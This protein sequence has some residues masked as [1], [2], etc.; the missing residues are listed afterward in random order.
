[1]NNDAYD[2]SYPRSIDFSHVRENTASPPH[3]FV[4]YGTVGHY[5]GTPAY[6]RI[7]DGDVLVEVTLN[8][9][10][11][12]VS[13]RVDFDTVD[14]GGFYLPLSY[15]QRVVVGF[16]NGDS[17]EAVIIGRCSDK[18][19]PFPDEV[20]DVATSS[21][22][23]NAPCFAFLKTQDGQLLCIETG[24]NADI[25]IHSGASVQLKATPSSQNL[26]TGRTHIGSDVEFSS[27]PTAATVAEDG[28]VEEGEA[29]G[30]FSPAPNSKGTTNLKLQVYPADGVVR[31]DDGIV[32][33]GITDPA[34][35]AW[36]SAVSAA[37]IP[38]IPT[39]PLQLKS[40]HESCSFNT[41]GD[42]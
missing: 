40:A 21:N 37:L 12:Q 31:M 5:D 2:R 13:A 8:P 3:N 27:P 11:D 23:K 7:E 35:F 38:P 14:G 26:I 30:L 41:V 42:D 34:F 36:V 33:N 29:G 22:G 25:V 9:S 24:T 17:S 18:S 20:C 1:M 19:W 6:V 4:S 10:G 15:G 39:F 32:S 28:F 16:P